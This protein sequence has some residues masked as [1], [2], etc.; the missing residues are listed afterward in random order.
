MSA[1]EEALSEEGLPMFEHLAEEVADQAIPEESKE[2]VETPE[3]PVRSEPEE[4]DE[5]EDGFDEGPVEEPRV[6][7]A[8]EEPEKAR[9]S[10]E[11]PPKEVEEHVEDAVPQ[12]EEPDQPQEPTSNEPA[13]APTETIEEVKVPIIEELKRE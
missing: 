3:D 8:A 13:P 7:A 2:H 10:V 12:E 5:Y 6:R 9:E 11:V 4:R 1:I